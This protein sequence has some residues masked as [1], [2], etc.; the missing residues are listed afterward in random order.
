MSERLVLTIVS[1]AFHKFLSQITHP[2]IREYA[3]RVVADFKV[4]ELPDGRA[5][6]CNWEKFQI[7]RLLREY[8]RVLYL[9]TDVY[10][11][12]GADDIFAETPKDSIGLYDEF[13]VNRDTVNHF[14]LKYLRVLGYP[15]ERLTAQEVNRY[16]NAGVIL[17]SRGHEDAFTFPAVPGAYD[18]DWDLFG[19]QTVLNFNI[20][21][22]GVKVKDF[23]PKF[24]AMMYYDHG[25]D[26][27]YLPFEKCQFFHFAGMLRN[28][29]TGR[30]PSS[31]AAKFFNDLK[32]RLEKSNGRVLA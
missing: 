32:V 21:R 18:H 10:I 6:A 16:F 23:G 3:E 24:N 19:D 12:D 20:N 30:N 25:S 31:R 11:K 22:Y 4:I 15:L 28:E 5:D 1:G 9:D 7:P 2:R 8:E 29:T 17:A 13:P 27:C 14:Y 26:I